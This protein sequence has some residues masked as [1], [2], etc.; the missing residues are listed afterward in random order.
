VLGVG[1]LSVPVAAADD[2]GSGFYGLVE[3]AAVVERAGVLGAAV[4]GQPLLTGDRLTTARSGRAEVTL[5]DGTV[6]HVAGAV[7]FAELAE[8]GERDDVANLLLLERGELLLASGDETETRV[9]TD[10]ATVY[11]GAGAYRLE[12]DDLA[13]RVV[14]RR[15]DAE[16]RTRR[17]ALSVAAGEQ[18][19]IEGD[20][21][22]VVRPAGSAD[23]LER[24][25]VALFEL[26]ERWAW[27]P[28]CRRGLWMWSVGE[29]DDG[30]DL[31]FT[32]FGAGAW[33]DDAPGC[34]QSG[35]GARRTRLPH[36][37]T[38]DP[39]RFAVP[40]PRESGP[41]VDVAI[42]TP[43]AK[44]W[45]LDDSSAIDTTPTPV[46]KPQLESDGDWAA[47]GVGGAFAEEPT[48]EAVAPPTSSTDE[49]W[50]L[51]DTAGSKD[52][53][54]STSPSADASVADVSTAD[55]SASTDTSGW[56]TDTSAAIVDTS[57]A[58]DDSASSA[59]AAGD[60]GGS[61]AGFVDASPARDPDI[62]PNR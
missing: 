1:V 12:R 19:S 42:E 23:A 56:T 29:D 8:P 51:D 24:W 61:D 13:T 45:P 44:P 18:A 47:A 10:N 58:S 28:Q 49:S 48:H 54:P 2:D 33:D 16:L 34:F 55:T 46:A 30:L 20:D 31:V 15:G 43:V 3:G 27:C 50:R 14:V 22:L 26:R 4:E 6:I 39:G 35:G 52:E 11:L 5:A 7:V 59:P 57:S 21:D 17:G 38:D 53:T 62:E 41:V 37:A 40:I 60:T 25:A 9:D 36:F 32:D